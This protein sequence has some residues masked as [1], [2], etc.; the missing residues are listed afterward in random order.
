MS[1]DRGVFFGQKPVVCGDPVIP[2]NALDIWNLCDQARKLQDEISKIKTD[3]ADAH[4]QHIAALTSGRLPEAKEF[5]K[6]ALQVLSG[7]KKLSQDRN[8]RV[9]YRG[10][11]VLDARE[12]L[13]EG[14]PQ[15]LPDS[16]PS[17]YADQQIAKPAAVPKP[18]R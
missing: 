12:L 4:Q 5:S 14:L 11:V 16:Y 8:N 10:Q 6:Q 18:K 2:S 1:R 9:T 3:F 17:L 7:L 13:A 15:Y